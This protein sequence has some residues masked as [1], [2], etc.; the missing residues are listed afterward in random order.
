MVTKAILWA[1]KVF[2]IF[3]QEGYFKKVL[4]AAIVAFLLLLA[5]I[6]SMFTTTIAT[7]LMVLFPAPELLPQDIYYRSLQTVAQKYH[8]AN[9]IPPAIVKLIHFHMIGDISDNEMEITQFIEDYLVESQEISVAVGTSGEAENTPDDTQLD[10]VYYFSDLTTL[11]GSLS[12][13]PFSFAQEDI[14]TIRILYF[15][16]ND[17]DAGHNPQLRGKYPMPVMGWISSGFGDRLDPITGNISRH[18]ALDIVPVWHAPVKAIADGVVVNI[19]VSRIYG[20]CITIAHLHQGE[21]FTTFSAH[22]SRVDI[23]I[24][25]QLRQGDIIGLEGGS[26][27]LD[28][29]L[30]RTTGHHLHFEVWEGTDRSSAVDPA[31]YLIECDAV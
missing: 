9:T 18:L 1:G 14:E 7:V 26:H 3:E 13:P 29:N 31:I 20:N 16:M 12:Q 10:T 17:E 23:Q 24:G 11:L 25:Q 28:P 6:I 19:E 2:T 5:L 27:D 4:L 30:G 21:T 15:S 8:I 22:L